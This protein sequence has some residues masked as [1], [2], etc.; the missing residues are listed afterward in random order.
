MTLKRYNKRNV[1]LDEKTLVRIG[2][3]NRN[4]QLKFL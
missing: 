4:Y 1:Q 3:L 2:F